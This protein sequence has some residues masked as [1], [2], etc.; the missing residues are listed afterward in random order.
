M[1]GVVKM[2]KRDYQIYPIGENENRL[3][4][5]FDIKNK[6][7]LTTFMVCDVAAFGNWISENISNV[8]SGKEQHLELGGNVCTIDVTPNTTK[9]YI[10]LIEDDEEYYSTMCEVDTKDLY[11]VIVEWCEKLKQFTREENIKKR[12]QK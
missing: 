5:L 8:L 7:T 12:K 4:I 9:I 2:L 11:E 3:T 6:E 1:M 10:E